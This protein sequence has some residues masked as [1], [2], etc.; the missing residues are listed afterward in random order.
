MANS[1]EAIVEALAA[2]LDAFNTHDLERIM[3]MFAEDCILQMPRGD[4]RW[5]SCFVGKEAV[6]RGLAARFSG[7]PNVHYGDATH[8]VSG[9]V[10]ITKWTL[11]GTQTSGNRGDV[12]GCDSYTFK[13]DKV[14]EKD[15]YW[16]IVERS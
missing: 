5:G 1:K 11:T 14:I 15:S 10:G 7:I 2:L 12:L 16:K 13:D 9:D 8:F 6:R 3:S 4:R